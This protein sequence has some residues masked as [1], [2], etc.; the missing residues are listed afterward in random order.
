MLWWKLLFPGVGGEE[1]EVFDG[2]EGLD[3][4]LEEVDEEEDL[5]DEIDEDADEEEVKPMGRAQKRIMNLNERAQKAEQDRDRLNKE[6]EEARKQ[7][8]QQPAA[9]V[10]DEVWEQEEAVLKDPNATDWQR[11]AVNSSRNSRMASFQAQ[12]ALQKAHDIADKSDF[13][14]LSVTKPKL[15]SSYKDRVEEMHQSILKEGRMPPARSRLLSFLV[16]DDMVNDKFK[17]TA[18]KK[19]SGVKRTTPPGARSDVSAKGGRLSEAEK[20]TKRLEGKI[21]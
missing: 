1:D 3:D 10:K 20:R 4:E 12:Q 6:L 16:G 5:E 9:R 17:P 19:S 13:D 11:Y 7:Y 8:S 18:S 21:I 14:R 2:G 15:Y